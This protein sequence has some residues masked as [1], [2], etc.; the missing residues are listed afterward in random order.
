MKHLTLCT[1]VDGLFG[2]NLTKDMTERG[3]AFTRIL[4][5][6]ERISQTRVHFLEWIR[7]PDERGVSSSVGHT[8]NGCAEDYR[9]TSSQ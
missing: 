1:I 9:R 5:H 8:G 4:E 7:A 6:S 2:V 3:V